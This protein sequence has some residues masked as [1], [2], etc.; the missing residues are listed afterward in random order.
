MVPNCRSCRHHSLR[1]EPRVLTRAELIASGEYGGD[2]ELG[3]LE[4]LDQV[5]THTGSE[6]DV[7]R[8]GERAFDETFSCVK[9]GL[10]L[11]G[12]DD[13]AG[14]GCDIWEAGTK[15]GGREL[16]PHLLRR[17]AELDAKAK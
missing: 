2:A 10:R 1:K 15:G 16:P 5:A 4:E 14:V 17:M 13:N 3:M 11:I 7:R 8:Y 6:D 12:T 9:Q